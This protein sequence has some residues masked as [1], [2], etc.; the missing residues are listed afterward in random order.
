MN[1]KLTRIDARVF[2][3][4]CQQLERL[5][6]SK[7]QIGEIEPNSFA[8]LSN[9]KELWLDK[10][11]LKRIEADTFKGLDQL[12]QL[13]LNYNELE[14]INPSAF[15]S[16]TSLRIMTIIE[17]KLTRLTR[18]HFRCLSPSV[19]YIDLRSNKFEDASKIISFYNKPVLEK[20]NSN[21]WIYLG[22]DLLPVAKIAQVLENS[23]GS[24]SDF[25]EFSSQFPEL[26]CK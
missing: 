24:K 2:E 21:C 13:D 17:N 3:G 1:N 4:S 23:G 26:E 9:L 5:Y 8:S 6:L 11:K 19:G 12:E 18:T 7:N 22:D 25:S 14:E 10:N 20:W 15:E 16:L